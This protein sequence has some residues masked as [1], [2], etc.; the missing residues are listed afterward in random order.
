MK[1]IIRSM[2]NYLS[3]V[4]ILLPYISF[5]I[6]GFL[7]FPST[8]RDDV[9]ITYWQ[10][11]TLSNFGEMSNYNGDAIEQSSSLL[12]VLI[13]SFV[14]FL[15]NLN[16][17]DLGTILSIFFGL[18]SIHLIGVLG[19]CFGIRKFNSRIVLS[20][21]SPFLYWS[22]GA[23]ESSLVSFVVLCFLIDFLKEK[24]WKHSI[25]SIFL[26][27]LVRPE[28]VFVL[29]FFYGLFFFY[30]L[31]YQKVISN[32]VIQFFSL[33][34]LIFS[35][36]T[37][38]RY[39]YFDA[40]F[41]QS[42]K[43][44]TGADFINT[45]H[46]GYSY[47]ITS[48]IDYP[49]YL[50][51]AFLFLSFLLNIIRKKLFS[52]ELISL[53]FFILS[54]MSFVFTSGGDW[55]EGSRFFVPLIGP[56]IIFALSYSLKIKLLMLIIITLNIFSSIWFVTDVS[57]SEPLI[58]HKKFKDELVLNNEFSFF[59]KYNKVH[60]RDVIFIPN[61]KSVINQ[62]LKIDVEPT[63]LSI[64]AGMVPFHIM[65]EY[66]GEVEFIDFVGLSTTHFTDCDLT[67]S[68]Q[69]QRTGINISYKYFLSNSK[70]I[71]NICGIELPIIIYDL[72]DESSARMIEIKNSG[73]YTLVYS[74]E[75]SVDNNSYFKGKEIPY[76]QFIFVR[77]DIYKKIKI[78]IK[79]VVVE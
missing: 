9:H 16:I 22:F 45:L 57:T 24:S 30:N 32:R 69:K 12:H 5:L 21:S 44:K 75:G 64:Q 74:I 79:H 43:A 46:A 6:I 65:K 76:N 19:E 51:Y 40:F 39:F 52:K 56:L 58:F 3:K 50:V 42:V 36:I 73:Y 17:V 20:T 2:N 14:Q 1:N 41:P 48:A 63:I 60:Y 71:E 54:Y 4:K 18:V 29:S 77:N 47:F 70:E 55:M 26:L 66:F 67:N 28:S 33:T 68:F 31:L 37:V 13:L 49:V 72:G 35:L 8:G 11:Y 59:E 38:F 25:G 7:F 15:T 34:V 61:L 53:F 78:I 27:L 23:L 62:V 10:S